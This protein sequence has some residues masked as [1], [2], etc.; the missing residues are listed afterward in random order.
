MHLP[1]W[2]ITCLSGLTINKYFTDCSSHHCH[3]L[4]YDWNERRRTNFKYKRCKKKYD[5]NIF[6]FIPR[7]YVT[8]AYF[9]RK[10]L[11][12]RTFWNFYALIFVLTNKYFWPGEVARQSQFLFGCLCD[13]CKFFVAKK[14]FFSSFFFFPSSFLRNLRKNLFD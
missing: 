9:W 11:E 6:L 1:C 10:W 8:F 4:K 14:S 13:F 12:F 5:G 3:A 7:G 2:V